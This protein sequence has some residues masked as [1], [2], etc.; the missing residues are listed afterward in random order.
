[1]LDLFAKSGALVPWDVTPWQTFSGKGMT[2]SLQSYAW[3]GS[4]CL[5]YLSMRA[6]FGLMKMETVICT[7]RTKDLPLYSY[8]LINAFGR[9][10]LIVEVYDTQVEPADLSSMQ[11][12][13]DKYRDLNDKQLKPA[14]YDSLRLSPSTAKTGSASRLKQLT[15]EITTAYVN[16]FSAARDIDP[17][18]KIVRNRTYV[19]GLISNGGPA[20]NT[21]RQILGNEA[22]ERLF[23]RFLFGTE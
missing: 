23:R 17:A 8:D 6:F 15:T 13:K 7:P 2:F 4:A 10:T 11:A 3:D 14:W 5:S 18:V 12:V 16:L 9:H 1:M 19:E 21:I 22:A 20:I